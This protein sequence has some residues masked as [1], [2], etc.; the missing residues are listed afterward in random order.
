MKKTFYHIS[1]L[2]LILGMSTSAATA[3]E[4]PNIL[5]IMGDDRA[6]GATQADR[7]RRC[8][9]IGILLVDVIFMVEQIVVQSVDT[10]ALLE[11]AKA[12]AKA[13]AERA[14]TDAEKSKAEAEKAKTKANGSKTQTNPAQTKPKQTPT[15]ENHAKSNAGQPDKSPASPEKAK[16]APKKKQPRTEKKLKSKKGGS[17]SNDKSKTQN[18]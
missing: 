14:K 2:L 11:K 1:I 13:K 15:K 18:R 4:K 7:H 6:T 17:K 16:P 3:A 8:V 9:V 12:E 5:V 10:D